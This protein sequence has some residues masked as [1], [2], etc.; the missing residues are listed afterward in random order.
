MQKLFKES[1]DDH[2]G[3]DHND[4]D[5]GDDIYKRFERLNNKFDTRVKNLNHI[6]IEPHNV[7]CVPNKNADQSD[8]NHCY[9][10]AHNLGIKL[11]TRN[12]D[13]LDEINVACV[14]VWMK[15]L[16]SILGI[17]KWRKLH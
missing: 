5:D 2:N 1:N 7:A 17:C 14:T 3:N 13:R 6:K 11:S 15:R 12:Q 8:Q 10:N 9:M 16:I 4:D